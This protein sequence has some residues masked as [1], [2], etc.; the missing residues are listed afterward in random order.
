MNF[1]DGI[2]LFYKPPGISSANF[3]NKIKK[4]FYISKLVKV[5][6]GG[7]LDPIAQ[8]LIVVGVGRQYTKMLITV[9]RSLPKT[10]LAEIV[11]GESSDTYDVEGKKNKKFSIKKLPNYE[12]IKRALR[13]ICKRKKQTP[14]VFS[15]I[16]IN[17]K[18]AFKRAR[19]GEKMKMKTRSVRVIHCDLKNIKKEVDKI[20]LNIKIEVSSGFYIRSFANDLGDYLKVGGYLNNLTRLKIGDFKIPDKFIYINNDNIKNL[21]IKRIDIL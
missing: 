21:L 8:G 13:I 19:A 6:H 7:T 2:Y 15:A 10:Y 14:P 9:L 3:L 16:K 1:R 5:G 4:E 17:G 20:I 11:L 12:E 18:E